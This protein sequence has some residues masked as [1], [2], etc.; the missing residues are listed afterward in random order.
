MPAPNY[1][2]SDLNMKRHQLVLSFGLGTVMAAESAAIFDIFIKLGL[3]S[4][5]E[6][7]DIVQYRC[8]Q[9]DE[10]RQVHAMRQSGRG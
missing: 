9:V 6:Y 3:V 1:G 4:P 5:S 2:T 7:L 8:Q 10:A